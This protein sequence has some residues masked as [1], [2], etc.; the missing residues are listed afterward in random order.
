MITFN[1]LDG[2]SYTGEIPNLETNRNIYA[3][4][5]AEFSADEA[6]HIEISTASYI[7]LMRGM[8]HRLPESKDGNLARF[9]FAMEHPKI[10]DQI[11]GIGRVR[12]GWNI[13]PLEQGVY[14]PFRLKFQST[15]PTRFVHACVVRV[16]LDMLYG[17]IH[18]DEA[19]TTHYFTTMI[20]MKGPRSWQT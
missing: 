19:I 16:D 6:A 1:F 20:S 13:G 17:K 3:T 14:V 8:L 12:I 9:K 5:P 7:L 4:F 10:G 2:S 11:L 15:K 18:Y